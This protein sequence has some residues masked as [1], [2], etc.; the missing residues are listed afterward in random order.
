MIYT[1]TAEG[2]RAL[3][4]VKLANTVAKYNENVKA[5]LSVEHAIDEALA[6]GYDAVVIFGSL[7]FLGEAYLRLRGDYVD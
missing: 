6:S 4:A 2:E 7:S 1:V 5:E 3:S